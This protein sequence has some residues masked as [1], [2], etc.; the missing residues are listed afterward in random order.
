[1]A[2]STNRQSPYTVAEEVANSLTHGLGAVLSAA[3]LTGLVV[4]AA[5][6]ADPWRIASV[7]VFGVTLLL[8]YVAST[9]YHAIPHPSAKDILRVLDHCA[10]FLLIAGTYTPFALVSMRGPWGWTLFTILWT[11]AIAGCIFKLF[12]TGRWEKLSTAMYVAMGW[13]AIIAIKP[14]IEMIPP[15]A[16]GFVVL[17][18][19]LYTVG[20]AFYVWERLPYNH[21]IWHVFVLGGS[22][23]HFVAVLFWVARTPAITT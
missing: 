18:G 20:V 23:A 3:G 14:A 13:M 7:T 15:G 16:L 10:I 2:T 21:A 22:A 9:L 11:C 19:L 5:M 17:G 8:T 12:F 1:M 6:G 4:Y